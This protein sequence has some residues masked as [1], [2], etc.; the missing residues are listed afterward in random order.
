MQII[1]F[2]LKVFVREEGSNL[3]FAP[4]IIKKNGPT[5]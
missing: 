2:N 5:F 1:L 3:N 4:K